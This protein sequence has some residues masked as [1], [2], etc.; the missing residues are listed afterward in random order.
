MIKV[1]GSVIPYSTFPNGELNFK[2]I[3]E[4]VEDTTYDEL[5]ITFKYET[6]AD[7]FHLLLISR[8]AAFRQNNLLNLD[9]AYMPYSRMDRGG[10]SS[11]NCS[12]RT[13]GEL[14]KAMEFDSIK[15]C[16]PHSDLT[17][18]YLG[19][20][21]TAYYPFKSWEFDSKTV[22]M[23]PDS[24]AQ[25]RYAGM[26]CFSHNEQIVGN[27]VRDFKTGKIVSYEV[28]NGKI[29]ADRAI[30]IVDDLC[31]YGGT[32]KFAGDEL[33][34]FNPKRIDL[35]VS[36]CEESITKGKLFDDDS[37]I[38]CVWTTNSII[39]Q[40]TNPKLHIERIF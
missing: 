13:V 26:S 31:S 39:E 23:F 34:K 10:Y 17:L 35:M 22:I 2:K 3:E 5:N 15:V 21:A 38:E 28:S 18:A 40:G 14:I 37:P 25:K 19:T 27:K 16:D 6:D 8:S 29:V 24:G 4:F 7:L 33:K 30:M 9:I 12:L 11:S 32:F 36:H 20:N 1:N